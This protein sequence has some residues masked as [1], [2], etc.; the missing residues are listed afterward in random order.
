[1]PQVLEPPVCPE[2][3]SLFMSVYYGCEETPGLWKNIFIKLYKKLHSYKIYKKHFIEA[4]LPFRALVQ[5]HHCGKH[6]GM[7]TDL[8]IEKWLSVPHPELPAAE[9][10]RNWPWLEL[11]KPQSDILPLVLVLLQVSQSAEKPWKGKNKT[12]LCHSDWNKTFRVLI[13]WFNSLPHSDTVKLW[14]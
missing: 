13:P 5:Y 8:V 10:G 7:H 9:R 14:E 2:R 11:L 6:D 12:R 1:M 3:Q 4:C